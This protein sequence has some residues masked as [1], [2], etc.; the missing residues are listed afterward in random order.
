MGSHDPAAA[1]GPGF[2]V[3][4]ALAKR[5]ARKDPLGFGFKL[6]AAVFVKHPE[7]V[8]VG[9]LVKVLAGLMEFHDPA[10]FG[11]FGRDGSG[12]LQHRFASRRCAFLRQITD[13][14]V[15]LE[16]HPARVRGGF[17]QKK[18][19]EGGFAGAVG[20]HQPD[21][22]AP[23]DLKRHVF[24]QD[25]AAERFTDLR[26]G[27]HCG[28]RAV[29]AEAGSPRKSSMAPGNRPQQGRPGEPRFLPV[30][31]VPVQIKV[32]APT[33][34]DAQGQCVVGPSQYPRRPGLIALPSAPVLRAPEPGGRARDEAFARPHHPAKV[35]GGIGGMPLPDLPVLGA[36]NEAARAHDHELAPAIGDVHGRFARHGRGK[37]CLSGV[38]RGPPIRSAPGA[39]SLGFSQQDVPGAPLAAPVD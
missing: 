6:P 35:G 26:D 27:E 36:F 4:V 15:F 17:A 14:G 16:R 33:Q 11:Q 38:A 25:A 3:K 10:G 21:S 24:K 13:R 12:Q 30:F 22:V 7:R 28:K 39:G 37:P 9:V 20:A 1:H 31:P 8:V 19:K 18:G 32:S 34:R 29:S 5:Q 2:P 23:V